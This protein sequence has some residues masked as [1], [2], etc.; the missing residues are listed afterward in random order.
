METLYPFYAGDFLTQAPSQHRTQE[1][2]RADYQER[3]APHGAIF[4]GSPEQIFDKIRFAPGKRWWP[5]NSRS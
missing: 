1:I 2:M 5:N 3:P 4:V